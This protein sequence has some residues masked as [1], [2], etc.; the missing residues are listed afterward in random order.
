MTKKNKPVSIV[1]VACG[2]YGYWYLRTLFDEVAPGKYRLAGV[3][4]PSIRQLP[5]FPELE[6][7]KIPIYE[8]LEDFYREQSADLAVISSP[9]HHHVPQTLLALRN[10]SR[11]LCDKPLGVTIQ[12]VHELIRE[13]ARLNGW[14]SIGYQWTFSR[15]IRSLKKDILQGRF[16]KP[17]RFKSLALWPRDQGY[18]LRNNWAGRI[19][20][21]GGQWIL[22]S[23]ANNAMAHDLHNMLYLLGPSMDTSAT[24]ASV[25]AEAYKVYP[26]GNFD[27]VNARIST[28]EG[29]ELLFYASHATEKPVNPMF[30]IDCEDAYITYTDKTKNIVAVRKK[31]KE[32]HYGSPNHDHQ[33]KK[34]F[35]A[36]KAVHTNGPMICSPEAAAAQTLCVN[37]IQDS[38]RDSIPFPSRLIRRNELKLYI[39]G[40]GGMFQQCYHKNVLLHELVP[41][42][43]VAGKNISL[44]EYIFFPGG[45]EKKK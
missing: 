28:T 40:L 37:G 38:L 21:E 31:G 42:W 25:I 20:S 10:H 19:R 4:D 22:D 13:R 34:L 44:K 14:V 26:I 1:A 12:E 32:K 11:V 29:T 35:H 41:G 39:N 7:G 27:T 16:G 45:K 15:A 23:P 8:H 6:Q 5:I 33:F 3:V 17:L 36:I 24:P 18:Y 30:R 2:G 9:I 43:T